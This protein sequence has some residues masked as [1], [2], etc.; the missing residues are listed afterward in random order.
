MTARPEVAG[1]GTIQGIPKRHAAAVV[2]LFRSLGVTLDS[3]LVPFR[4]GGDPLGV[5]VP[6]FSGDKPISHLGWDRDG[7]L[8]ITQDQPLPMTLVGVY[9]LM[10]TEDYPCV[11]AALL[12]SDAGPTA[13]CWLWLG[14]STMP[15]LTR[16]RMADVRDCRLEDYRAMA[17]PLYPRAAPRVL[18]ALAESLTTGGPA[19][20]CTWH[21]RAA[22]LRGPHAVPL[23]GR[24]GRVGAA[25]AGR[26]GASPRRAP[27][28]GHV[29][30]AP[31]RGRTTCAASRRTCSRATPRRSGGSSASGSSARAARRGGGPG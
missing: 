18:E 12:V 10:G 4:R 9:S 7:R 2:R 15:T 25:L 24:G 20:A 27:G 28:R 5:G 17:G 23:A 13:G 8:T 14:M 3:T 26:Q 31:H 21:G 11:T 22:A 16:G 19:F 1:L 6:L 29:P 30:R